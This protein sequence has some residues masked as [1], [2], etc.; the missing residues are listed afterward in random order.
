MHDRTVVLF[1]TF[2][3]FVMVI[4]ATTVMVVTYLGHRNEAQSAERVATIQQHSER[5]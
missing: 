4:I 3:I 2:V 1:M 5:A